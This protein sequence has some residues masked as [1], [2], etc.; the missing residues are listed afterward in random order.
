MQLETVFVLN[1]NKNTHRGCIVSND[2]GKL[3]FV[4]WLKPAKYHQTIP[5][6][7]RDEFTKANRKLL[8]ISHIKNLPKSFTDIKETK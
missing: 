7:L 8:R 6:F 3:T 2:N 4:K 1:P 5:D